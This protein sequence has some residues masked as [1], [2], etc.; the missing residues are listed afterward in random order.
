MKTRG[1][2]TVCAPAL[3]F[4]SSSSSS[5]PVRRHRNT[6]GG[7]GGGGQMVGGHDREGERRRRKLTIKTRPPTE[8]GNQTLFL[9]LLLLLR[10]RRRRSAGMGFGVSSSFLYRWSQKVFS[11]E[12]EQRRL[13][14][15]E[16]RTILLKSIPY[17]ARPLLRG[18][19]GC[20]DEEGGGQKGAVNN[21]ASFLLLLLPWSM[22]GVTIPCPAIYI[23]KHFLFPF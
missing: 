8:E 18:C 3:I 5:F 15:I 12:K 6:G 23:A 9:F 10:W 19:C 1:G 7:G 20:R 4:P 14:Q 17:V 2:K 22:E 16:I 11:Y 13:R 21:F